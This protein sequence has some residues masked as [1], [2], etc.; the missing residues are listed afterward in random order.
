MSLF[1]SDHAGIHAAARF[2]NY[3]TR[4][5]HLPRV[6]ETLTARMTCDGAPDARLR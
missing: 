3:R 6:S 2:A 5:R 4:A 1:T